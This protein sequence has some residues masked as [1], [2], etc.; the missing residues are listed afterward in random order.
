ML[1]FLNLASKSLLPVH[2]QF[3]KQTLHPSESVRDKMCEIHDVVSIFVVVDKSQCVSFG[4]VVILE[5]I[6]LVYLRISDEFAS[7][8]PANSFIPILILLKTRM[9][10]CP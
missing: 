4:V 3:V 5:M 8:M 10:S 1:W 2:F 6:T 9:V 7:S